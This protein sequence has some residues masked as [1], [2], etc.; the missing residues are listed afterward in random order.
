M[1]ERKRPVR[2]RIHGKDFGQF[3]RKWVLFSQCDM[4]VK[5]FGSTK[6]PRL[7]IRSLT[8]AGQSKKGNLNKKKLPWDVHQM[9]PA[10]WPQ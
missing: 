1:F 6:H 7:R 8:S 9:V 4:T 3:C 10:T 5:V 2:G